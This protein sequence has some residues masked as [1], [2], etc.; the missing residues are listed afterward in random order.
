MSKKP[1]SPKHGKKIQNK[2][3]IL[4]LASD[5][6]VDPSRGDNFSDSD[7]FAAQ[8]VTI[9][10]SDNESR[11]PGALRTW[12]RSEEEAKQFLREEL[13]SLPTDQLQSRAREIGVSNWE[14]MQRDELLERLVE[15]S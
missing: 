6:Y 5:D 4:E 15:A 2:K 1:Y 14:Q 8:G 13:D 12:K 7:I 11:E 9:K 10:D 3:R